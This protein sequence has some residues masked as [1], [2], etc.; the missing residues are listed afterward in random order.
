MSR[1]CRKKEI[2]VRIMLL[3][4]ALSDEYLHISI[5]G[6]QLSNLVGGVLEGE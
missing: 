6:N 5:T 2:S 3:I 4:K 1:S